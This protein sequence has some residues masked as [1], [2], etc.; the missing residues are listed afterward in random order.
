MRRP[1]EIDP[2]NLRVE[3]VLETILPNETQRLLLPAPDSAD[4]MFCFWGVRDRRVVWNGTLIVV[5]WPDFA[6]V[7]VGRPQDHRQAMETTDVVCERLA[8]LPDSV[9]LVEASFCIM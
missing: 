4:G 1:R 2:T 8:W 5:S 9:V 3:T 6:S 7:G